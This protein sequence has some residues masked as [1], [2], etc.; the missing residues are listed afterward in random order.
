MKKLSFRTLTADEVECRIGTYKEGK[1]MSLLLYK[2]ARVDQRLLDEVVGPYN[3]KN[4]YEVVKN[5]LHCT[6]SIYDSEK[7]EWIS[8]QNCGT[9]SFTE[10]Q[11][12]EASDAFKRAC[13]N[14]GIG[15]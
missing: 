3:W 15:R 9:E 7:N 10:A 12:G 13:F 4:S 1:G 2:D 8:K 5:V 11:K 6:V 14:W